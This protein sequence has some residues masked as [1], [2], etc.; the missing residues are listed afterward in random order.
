[1]VYV[2]LAWQL[3]I[4]AVTTGNDDAT[5]LLL[6]RAVGQ[7][8]Y[9]DFY[10]VGAPAHSQYPPFYPVL[11]AITGFLSGNH[12][13]AF[14]IL[15]VLMTAT[16]LALVFDVVRRLWSPELGLLLLATLVVN[17]TLVQL[18]GSVMSEAPYLLLSSVALWASTRP[19]VDGKWLFAIGVAAILAALTR[20]VGITLVAAVVGYWGGQRR[21][22]AVGI[23][24]VAATCLV[25]SWFAWTAFAPQKLVGR[26]YVADAVRGPQGGLW[27]TLWDRLTTRMPEYITK[28]VPAELPVPVIPG[29]PVDNIAWL[30]V[31]VA[32][33]SLGLVSIWRRWRFLLIY[34]ALYG[35]VLAVWTWVIGRFLAP[36]LPFIVLALLAGTDLLRRRVSSRLG[37]G[38]ALALTVI[39]CVTGFRST[40]SSVRSFAAC[41]RATPFDAPGCFNDD[42]LSLFAAARFVS[43]EAPDSAAVVTAKESTFAYYS[44]KHTVRPQTV[45]TTDPEEFRTL[46]RDNRADYV[47]LGRNKG[48]E[49][50]KL[51]QA[52][53]HACRWL[54]L[55]RAFPPRSYLFRLRAEMAADTTGVPCQ[56][57]S[58]YP[59]VMKLR[60]AS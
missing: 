24:V 40:L 48:I 39:V 47:F 20:S 57:L 9:R 6:S 1:M 16:A 19:A 12:L 36:L 17:P 13:D 25:G 28:I 49:F 32:L 58:R 42:Q 59:T 22:R 38:V 30:L 3:R 41:D 18:G 5:Y 50:G 45:L 56:L 23:F 33:G 43:T 7:L 44:G 29:T 54:E 34:L 31:L 11:L 14:L 55:E 8:H 52:L 60:E 37:I 53:W 51:P 27:F 26:S 46:M 2:Y 21:W 15:N 35:A 10:L 4:P